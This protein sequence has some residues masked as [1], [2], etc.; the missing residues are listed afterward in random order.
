MSAA[1]GRLWPADLA[2]ALAVLV[3][4]WPMWTA[5]GYGLARDL[6]FTPERP[7][8]LETL[9]LGVALP[10]AV[11]LDSFLVAF[12]STVGGEVAFR[13]CVA[14]V[15]FAAGLGASRALSTLLPQAPT[16]ARV[17]VA[18]LAVWNPM[19][20]ERLAM[21]QWALL[22]GYAAL[23][24]LLPSW[25]RVWAG[26][27]RRTDWG[28]ICAGSALASL[29]PTGGCV[30][31]LVALTGAFVH[32][33]RASWLA[34]GVAALAQAPWVSASLL[35]GHA[36]T[37]DALGLEAF[38]A[39]GGSVAEI[40]SLVAG[41]GIWN[42]VTVPGSHE[43]AYAV[44]G[45]LCCLGALIWSARWLWHEVP[46]LVLAAGL[47]VLLAVLPLLP[48][49]DALLAYALEAIPGAGLLRDSQ[50]WL[51][52]YVVVLGL[53]WGRACSTVLTRLR[54]IEIAP[55]LAGVA[56]TLPVLVLPDAAS[57][58]WEVTR[59]VTFPPDL[60]QAVERLDATPG[61]SGAVVTLPWASY[62]RFDWGLDL[63]APDPVA[64]WSAHPTVVSDALATRG[65][66]VA[67]EDPRTAEIGAALAGPAAG[68]G[69]RLA[70]LGVGWVLVYRDAEPGEDVDLAELEMI[71]EG[72]STQLWRVREAAVPPQDAPGGRVAM[73]A[74][75]H[76]IWA[77]LALL[78]LA[79]VVLRPRRASDL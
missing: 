16:V 62:R 25:C 22:A 38:S 67:G 60:A 79:A 4:S 59:P 10:R 32:R 42:S 1:R 12:T 6:V 5:R 50:K 14:G 36:L 49:G 44:V 55:I 27:S 8:T 46:A 13:A 41:G 43:G 20:V 75:A 47:G 15:L 35:G 9:G 30:V 70:R 34:F 58:T 69:A 77:L 23:W 63:S 7:W 68:L 28:V 21:G 26:A 37:S 45:A 65:G 54:D 66:E 71:Q 24:W 17:S 72:E 61:D 56:V 2:A 39:R 3:L 48:G 53:A 31:T 29:T 11:P 18:V 19:V 76:G 64:R 73:V 74:L 33:R 51:I 52:P 78:G 57:A 40:A